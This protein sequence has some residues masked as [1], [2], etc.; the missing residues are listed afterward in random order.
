MELMKITILFCLI[1]TNV[2]ADTQ[3]DRADTYYDYN[4][5]LDKAGKPKRLPCFN[6]TRID[7]LDDNECFILKI[8]NQTLADLIE[9]D[10]RKSVAEHCACQLIDMIK[11]WDKAYDYPDTRS[12]SH[13]VQVRTNET[14]QQGQ[15][16]PVYFWSDI[17][18]VS[19]GVSVYTSTRDYFHQIHTD[20][21]ARMTPH[22][23]Q[24]ISN[25]PHWRNIG[26]LCKRISQDRYFVYRYLENLA[27][28]DPSTFFR[29]VFWDEMI[30]TVYQA[31][32]ACKMLLLLRYNKY[33]LRPDDTTIVVANRAD[34]ETVNYNII[35]GA[36]NETGGIETIIYQAKSMMPNKCNKISDTQQK[37]GCPIKFNQGDTGDSIK[38]WLKNNATAPSIRSMAAVQCGCQLLLLNS[39]WD[40][41][42]QDRDVALMAKALTNYMNNNRVP[43]VANAPS[44][45][46]HGW[47]EDIMEKLT[48]SRKGPI[49]EIMKTL[50][51]SRE[52]P[53]SRANKDNVSE[54]SDLLTRGCLVVILNYDPVTRNKGRFRLVQYLNE[55]Q[56][57]SSD[58]KFV[59]QL[60]L[61][62][63]NLF[64]IYALS[65]M[66]LGWFY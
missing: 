11:W 59:F 28:L 1:G 4:I 2:L 14:M 5:E 19:Q 61:Q 57:I 52:D 12:V 60:T 20:P 25:D 58:N 47:F 65:K 40:S 22:Q 27:R 35:E 34:G 39:I 31:S 64:K 48:Q 46:L 15:G 17:D 6:T 32:K 29:L 3:E 43:D 23:R 9:K 41:M 50:G 33:K 21:A 44:W 24:L 8:F 7:D 45:I 56:S 62:N 42:L 13:L 18:I 49:K 51:G 26:V 66:C 54:A 37:S 16:Y 55:L 36:G 10:T 63:I 30:N 53:T 38:L